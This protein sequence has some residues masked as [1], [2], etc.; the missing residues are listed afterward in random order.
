MPLTIKKLNL[1]YQNGGA[2]FLSVYLGIIDGLLP[3][4]LI[5]KV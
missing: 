5:F 4:I 2:W 3:K 1:S